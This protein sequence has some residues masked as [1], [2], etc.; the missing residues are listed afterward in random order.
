MG[1]RLDNINPSKW[2]IVVN[3]LPGTSTY[4]CCWP[5]VYKD[6]SDRILSND[7]FVYVDNG[8]P[9]WPTEEVFWEV[10]IE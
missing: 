8:R 10:S 5:W 3:N 6:I 2:E 9:I 1:N 4:Y 7:L